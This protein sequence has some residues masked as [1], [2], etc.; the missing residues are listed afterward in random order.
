MNITQQELMILKQKGFTEQQISEAMGKLDQE[1][2]IHEPEADPRQFSQQSSF[3]V[4]PEQNLIKW[5]LEL[6]DILEQAEHI[7][8]GDIPKFKDGHQIWAKN[9]NPKLNSLNEFGIQEILKILVMYINRNTILSD[10]DKEEINFKIYDFG[11]RLNNLFFMRYEEF[12]MDTEDKRK[13]YSMIIG[14]LVDL[15][16]SAYKRAQHGGERRSL[17]EMI[18]VTQSHTSAGM[19]IGLNHGEPPQKERGMLNPLRYLKGKTK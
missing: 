12:G 6:N 2:E 16:H 17:R 4:I 13:N 14:E 7:L 18:S 1:E 3:S 10:Y 15:V 8:R 19:P 9:P 11:R 5:Q